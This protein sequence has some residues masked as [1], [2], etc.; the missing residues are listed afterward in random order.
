MATRRTLAG[1]P[2][3]RLNRPRAGVL[4]AA[5]PRLLRAAAPVVRPLI[6]DMCAGQGH[7]SPSYG[8]GTQARPA[9]LPR[10]AAPPAAGPTDPTST[11]NHVNEPRKK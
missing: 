10:A 1:P 9:R 7:N 3:S 6:G 8:G 4:R 11:D 2:A 5:A